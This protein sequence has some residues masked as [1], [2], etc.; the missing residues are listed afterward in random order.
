MLLIK[1]SL[2]KHF[3]IEKIFDQS[4]FIKNAVDEVIMAALIGGLLAIFILYF[5]LRNFWITFIISLSIP[6]S[7]ISTFNLMY[8]NDLTLNIMSL[9][10]ITLGIGMLLDNSIVVLENIFR[11]KQL[12]KSTVEAA[13]TGASEVGMAVTASTLTTVA[14]FFSPLF[15]LKEL[16]ANFSKIKH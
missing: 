10:G 15:L 11:H 12:G 7:V 14:V 13:K 6:V 9:G 1:K 3:N 2:P 8:G 16:P 5:F 4:I